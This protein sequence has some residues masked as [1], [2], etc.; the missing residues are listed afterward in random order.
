MVKQNTSGTIKRRNESDVTYALKWAAW[1]WLRDQAGCNA[2]AF[3]VRLEGPRGR[4]ADVVGLGPQN[5]VYV[6]EVK[7]SRSDAARDDN[8]KTKL[9]P[10]WKANGRPST[11]QSNSQPEYLRPQPGTATAAPRTPNSTWYAANTMAQ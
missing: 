2:I 5:R 3:E 8:T 6:V 10:N 7:A 1:R 11:K 4:I 9:Q